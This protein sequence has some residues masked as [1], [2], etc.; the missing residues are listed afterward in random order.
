M[1]GREDIHVARKRRS[2]TTEYTLDADR[3]VIDSGRST[4][5]VPGDVWLNE[6]LLDPSGC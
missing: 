1:V 6:G 2:A 5:E 3:R 4:G